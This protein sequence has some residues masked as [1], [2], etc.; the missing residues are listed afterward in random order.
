MQE[1]PEQDPSSLRQVYNYLITKPVST[2]TYGLVHRP[3]KAP[4]LSR[5]SWLDARMYELLMEYGRV[6]V[7]IPFTTIQI[8]SV[9]ELIKKP[10]K[11]QF[12][13]VAF[14]EFI[15]G[16][17]EIEEDGVKREY[18]VRY[19]PLLLPEGTVHSTKDYIG[20][21]YSL[22]YYTID[23]PKNHPIKKDVSWYSTVCVNGYYVIAYREPG[24]AV[25]YLDARHGIDPR[26]YKKK[27][28]ITECKEEV[29]KYGY[30]KAQSLLFGAMNNTIHESVPEENSVIYRLNNLIKQNSTF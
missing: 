21:R 11:G 10:I 6:H 19:R 7:P 5:Q 22:I 15:N 1:L 20:C 17:I 4:D 29:P 28:A 27:K 24:L 8:S 9:D 12:Y 25:R 14:G 16:E 13:Y 3:A 23:P 18:S 2:H 26:P 30:T